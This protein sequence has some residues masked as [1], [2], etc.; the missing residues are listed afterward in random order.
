MK[1]QIVVPMLDLKA[2]H[3]KIAAEVE[4]AVKAVL[5]SQQFILGPEVR[6]LESEIAAYCETRFAIGC[7][8]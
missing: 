5:E 8:S 7:A 1:K 4:A 3:E 2:Q 6:E